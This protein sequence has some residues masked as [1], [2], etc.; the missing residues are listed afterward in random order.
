MREVDYL[1][2]VD[3]KRRECLAAACVGVA[4]VSGCLDRIPLLSSCKLR[5]EVSEEEPNGGYG[6]TTLAYS[7]LSE[8]GQDVFEKALE[9]GSYVI[10][11]DGDNAPPDFTYSDEATSYTVEYEG[12][13]YVLFTYTDSG[14]TVE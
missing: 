12:E 8:K 2:M 7:E 11:Y 14:C 6:E 5:H 10:S 3:V 4:G 13:D 1:S 9:S